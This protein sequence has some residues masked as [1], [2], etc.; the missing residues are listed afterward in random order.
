MPQVGERGADNGP[1]R[2]DGS[3]CEIKKTNKTNET[4]ETNEIVNRPGTRTENRF[5]RF[6]ISRTFGRL[7]SETYASRTLGASPYLRG[8]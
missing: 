4:N 8:V 1:G 6:R 2:D 3:S 5:R 7:V